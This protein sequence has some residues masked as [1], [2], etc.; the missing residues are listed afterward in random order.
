MII[1]GNA[2]G[3]GFSRR[4]Q[5]TML[6]LMH[7]L[8]QTVAPPSA[9][10]TTGIITK[11]VCVLVSGVEVESAKHAPS[12]SKTYLLRWLATSKSIHPPIEPSTSHPPSLIQTGVTFEIPSESNIVLTGASKGKSA[13]VSLSRASTDSY[14]LISLLFAVSYA[15]FYSLRPGQAQCQC[16]LHR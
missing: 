12:M 1:V 14:P 15:C 4:Y 16:M 6:T 9:Q 10:F 7:A 3:F 5:L 13:T 11:E 2:F 8:H